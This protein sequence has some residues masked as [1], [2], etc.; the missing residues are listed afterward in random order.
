MRPS[1]V[2]DELLAIEEDVSFMRRASFL[3]TPLR[4]RASQGAQRGATEAPK[5]GAATT[6]GCAAEAPKGG[7]EAAHAE[8]VDA[9]AADAEA[10]DAEASPRKRPCLSPRA[11]GD[12]APPV[13]TTPS[14]PPPQPALTPHPAPQT[15]A[16][17]PHPTRTPALTPLPSP[18]G[19]DAQAQVALAALLMGFPDV[20]FPDAA[21]AAQGASEVRAAVVTMDAIL[22]TAAKAAPWAAAG[23]PLA[24]QTLPFRDAADENAPRGPAH[25]LA[26]ATP[27]PR[28]D[29][30][31]AAARHADALA[32]RA[33]AVPLTLEDDAR[34][35]PLVDDAR[36]F[37]CDAVDLAPRAFLASVALG[38]AAAEAEK[39][40]E[41]KTEAQVKKYDKKKVRT[42]RATAAV[43]TRPRSVRKATSAGKQEDS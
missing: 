38:A 9:E 28:T 37:P 43:G 19:G 20:G 36:L 15:P 10:A 27:P 42:A 12:A 34:L 25:R 40:N 41:A 6:E 29:A 31:A 14:R 7:A 2:N 24:K 22:A 35:F 1:L 33:G 17:T 16:L 30:V 32:A 13:A 39:R 3:D 23:L 26:A 11:A 8:A 21:A 18:G 4:K 5:G